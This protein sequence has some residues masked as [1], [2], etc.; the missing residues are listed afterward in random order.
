MEAA[1]AGEVR[2]DRA[3]SP[4]AAP[5]GAEETEARL[6]A[7]DERPETLPPL[8]LDRGRAGGEEASRDAT[9]GAPRDLPLLSCPPEGR[10]EEEEEVP[11]CGTSEE[12]PARG[13]A[14][15]AGGT[16]PE[17][18]DLYVLCKFVSWRIIST[19]PETNQHKSH[20]SS[21]ECKFCPYT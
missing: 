21:H 10:E 16:D 18:R 19:A 3:T 1:R 9:P 5:E 17:G 13:E 6:R 15:D 7:T 20:K 11:G 4:S 2:C 14:P 12:V 8:S